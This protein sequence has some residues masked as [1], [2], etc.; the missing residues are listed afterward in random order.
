MTDDLLSAE[1]VL[2]HLES[3]RIIAMREWQDR[4]TSD[5]DYPIIFDNPQEPGDVELQIIKR[6]D[7]CFISRSRVN[8]LSIRHSF[9]ADGIYS[10][11]SI[12]PA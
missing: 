9:N 5:H 6:K 4:N 11:C 1:C 3:L 2:R 7:R 8:I 12:K 10:E